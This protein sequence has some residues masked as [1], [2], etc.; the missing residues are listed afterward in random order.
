LLSGVVEPARFTV[1]CPVVPGRKGK[2]RAAPWPEGEPSRDAL[3]E[4][5]V[6]ERFLAFTLVC[7]RPVTGRTHQ[8][9]VHAWAAGHSL[10]VDP[11]YGRKEKFEGVERLTLH[12]LRYELPE[13]W[14]EPRSF[15]CP[16]AE[17]LKAAI[18]QNRR[19]PPILRPGAGRGDGL[20][21]KSPR[22][23]PPGLE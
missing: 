23:P 3:T 21:C 17:D 6:V 5:D 13:T 15:E 18:D 4:F 19:Q 11:L 20:E 22:W 2:M 16:L 14:G 9:R 8:I 10:A 1:H 7:A 12:A